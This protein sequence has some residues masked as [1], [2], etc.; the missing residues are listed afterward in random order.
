[1]NKWHE[2]F[3]SIA[4]NTANLSYCVRLKVGAIAVRDKRIICTGY[5]GTLP[6]SD[7]CC[8]YTVFNNETK[9]T[10]LK[11]KDETE[12][13]ERNLIAYAAK[14]GIA[15]NKSSLYITHAP[16]IDCAKAII[17]SGFTEVYWKHAYKSSS[18]LDL[19]H[20]YNISSAQL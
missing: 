13:A 15:L 18:G 2:Y 16:C 5:N 1:M 8:E 6:G 12:H 11:T 7:N 9:E 14:H 3:I 20:R 4:E 10:E 19:L 17:N